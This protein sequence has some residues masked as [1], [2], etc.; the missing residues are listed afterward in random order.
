MPIYEYQAMQPNNT[1]HKC[2]TGFE[3][4]QGINE[5]PLSACPSCGGIIKKVISC[6]HSA[7]LERPDEHAMVKKKIKEYEKSGM[8]SHAAELADTHSENL[9]NKGLKTRALENYKKAGYDAD[10]LAKHTETDND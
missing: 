3:V 8:W 10:S 5:E 7:V 2:Q 1:C 6:C 9:K 4:F